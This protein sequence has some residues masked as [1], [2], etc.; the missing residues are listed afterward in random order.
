MPF[1]F[2]LCLKQGVSLDKLTPIATGSYADVIAAAER[3]GAL[4]W[5][6]KTEDGWDDQRTTDDGTDRAPKFVKDS[7]LVIVPLGVLP[8]HKRRAAA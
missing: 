3:H 4:C 1:R 2:A 7:S 5:P 8:K 6:I